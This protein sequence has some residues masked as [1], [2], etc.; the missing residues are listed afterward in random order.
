[1]G[2][3]P[4]GEKGAEMAARHYCARTQDGYH[5]DDPSH[6]ALVVL[7]NE[8]NH[9]D[10]TF[11]TVQPDQADAEWRARVSLREDETY[12]ILFRDES[13]EDC[14]TITPTVPDVVADAL[15]RW[16][17]GRVIDVIP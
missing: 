10:N 8:L 4:V 14:E 13:G 15:S 6:V 7:I 1:M 17:T 16:L 9:V 11:M 3:Q 2:F 5:V 12:E